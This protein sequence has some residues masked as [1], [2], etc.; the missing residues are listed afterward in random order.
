M[1]AQPEYVIELI[2]KNMEGVL[3]DT[4][5]AKLAAARLIYTEAEW[6]QMT[7]EALKILEQNNPVPPLPNWKPPIMEHLEKTGQS[8]QLRMRWP[9]PR[10]AA[11]AVLAVTVAWL[12]YIF[13]EKKT[14][15]A[16][17]GGCE[18]LSEE[19][20]IPDPWL[21]CTLRLPDSTIIA[22]ES[23][24]VNSSIH[25]SA[26]SIR[27]LKHGIIEINSLPAPTFT[28]SIHKAY[29]EVQTKA[30]QQY[31]VILPNKATVLL[32]AGSSLKL[33]FRQLDSL[34]FVHL[35][36]QAKVTMPVN[37]TAAQRLI[38][39][40]SNTQI[41]TT[42]ASF[43]VL[44]LPWYSQTTLVNGSLTAFSR[45]GAQRKDMDQ[46]GEQV[47]ITTHKLKTELL[48]DSMNYTC[49]SSAIYNA[50]V[51]TKAVRYYDKV[52]LRQFVADMC[53]WYGLRIKN[54]HCIPEKE[55][56][57]TA[58][59]YLAPAQQLYAQIRAKGLSVREEHGVLSFCEP[60][61][62]KKLPWTKTAAPETALPGL[63]TRK[64]VRSMLFPIPKGLIGQFQWFQGSRSGGA[65][66]LLHQ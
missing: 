27:Q 43:A 38:L 20:S 39:E 61:P 50:L 66:R 51:W 19:R 35:Q 59:C 14:K 58:F 45:A 32:N 60:A 22:S 42:S 28:D 10:A 57:T 31:T 4:E 9:L 7:V 64:P 8:R 36:G 53:Q 11:I 41:Q 3:P 49:S 56:I 12:S 25:L 2:A 44:A 23:F 52:P 24:S 48:M 29:I 47:I 40:T 21:A 1:I 54:M 15:P 62:N 26:V 30:K 13:F 37:Q 17:I 55:R 46:P 33:S 34:C 16:I 5:R 65:T 18:Q 63:A 6:Q